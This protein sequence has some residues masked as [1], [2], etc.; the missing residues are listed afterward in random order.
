MQN[1]LAMKVI[2]YK[3][4]LRMTNETL[5]EKSGLPIGTVSRIASGQTKEPTLKTLRLIAKAFNCTVDDL[6]SENM[7]EEF[8]YDEKTLEITKNIEK[9][10]TLKLLFNIVPSLT[11]DN[12]QAVIGLAQR[13]LMLQ[14]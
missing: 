8:N 9:D 13:L 11:D 10:K 5:A 14:G 1:K 6:Q 12:K 7:S 2:Y 4:L 3:K